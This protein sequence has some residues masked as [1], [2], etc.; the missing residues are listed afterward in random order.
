MKCHVFLKHD[1]TLGTGHNSKEDLNSKWIDMVMFCSDAGETD[2]LIVT[3]Y[4]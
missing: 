4:I 3:D 2:K 1:P